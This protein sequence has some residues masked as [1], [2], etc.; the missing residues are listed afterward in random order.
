MILQFVRGDDF[1][2]K[3]IMWFSHA[4]YSHVDTVLPDGSLY[5]ARSDSVGGQPPG[6]QGRD[7]SYVSGQSVLRIL[8]SMPPAMEAKYFDFILA[9]KGKPYDKTAIWGF[10]FNRDWRETDSWFCSELVAA[11]LEACDYF[12]HPIALDA[13]K[14]TPADLI[15]ALSVKQGIQ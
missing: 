12:G 4:P 14:I 10:G 8:V 2:A 3:A 6:V 1:G 5:G 9:Q 15:L 11:G 7:P 13:N